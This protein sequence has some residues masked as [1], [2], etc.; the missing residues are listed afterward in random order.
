M[1]KQNNYL[2]V[3]MYKEKYDFWLIAMITATDEWQQ[4][5][6]DAHYVV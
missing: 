2:N 1:P 3:I 4:T 5:S 6:S